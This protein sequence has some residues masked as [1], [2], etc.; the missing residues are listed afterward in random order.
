M[1]IIANSR[2]Y[3]TFGELE[4]GDIFVLIAEGDFYFNDEEFYMKRNDDSAVR[5]I[6]GETIIFRATALCELKDCVLVER[7]IYK[8]LTDK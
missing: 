8:A 6:D 3:K 1:D 4:K 2:Q 5:L 7:E